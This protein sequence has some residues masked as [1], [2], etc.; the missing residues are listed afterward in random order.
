MY[1]VIDGIVDT[2]LSSNKISLKE[3]FT[4]LGPPEQ[5]WFLMFRGPSEIFPSPTMFLFFYP[6]NGLLVLYEYDFY[7]PYSLSLN[8]ITVCLEEI[9]LTV[10]SL[11]MWS[12]NDLRT[13]DEVAAL[14]LAR[15]DPFK[16][17]FVQ[18]E[19]TS[20]VESIDSLVEDY[21]DPLTKACFEID[22]T[23]WQ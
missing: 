14:N 1:Y 10:A 15:E 8:T 13:F 16:L 12:Q 22:L 3:F 17:Q 19:E 11:W 18:L 6:Q 4:N 20:S 23:I 5:V 21:L 9:E 7:I 2:I